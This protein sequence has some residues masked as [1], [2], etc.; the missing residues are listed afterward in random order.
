MVIIGLLGKSYPIMTEFLIDAY[1]FQVVQCDKHN[2]CYTLTEISSM[3]ETGSTMLF[4]DNIVTLKQYRALRFYFGCAI[5]Q[6]GELEDRRM[7]PDYF[8][9]KPG[10]GIEI[11]S[12]ISDIL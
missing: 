12:I 6:L 3:I 7:K 5:I 9:D 2:I 10:N 11:R 8:I 4:V 1:R